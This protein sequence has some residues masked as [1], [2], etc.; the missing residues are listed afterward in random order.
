MI[1]QRSSDTLV[2]ALVL[3]T[4]VTLMT[5]LV[6][7][8]GWNKRQFDLYMW[9]ESALDLNVD[10]RVTLKDLP[11]GDVKAVVPRIDS[12]T[13]GLRFL[14]HLR[15]NERFSDGTE[16][17]LPLGTT[18]D[19]AQANAL[20]GAVITLKYPERAVGTLTPGD[21]ITSVRRAAAL[22]AITEIADSLQRRLS[23]VLDD[24]RKLLT[25]LDGAVTAAR[26]ELSTTAPDVRSALRELQ[27]T[28]AGLRPAL[29]HADTLLAEM[30]TRIPGLHDSLTAT[31]GQ[32]RSL[33]EHL[34]SLAL[35]AG[36][37]ASENRE[38][39]RKTVANL[40]VLSVK[41][42]H[43]MDQV[44]RRPLR[45]ITG[46]TPPATDSIEEQKP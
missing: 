20:G 44:S 42:E 11:I 14:V 8:Q 5:A 9:A 24:S 13:G 35:T 37:V 40:F 38:S 30:D 16:L 3:G 43:F 34:D 32:T 4:I 7:T 17:R 33:V 23:L 25:N 27:G 22:D 36:A 41:M 26:G 28:L 19:I 1:S 46:V 10:T 12:T 18:A 45:M 29:A 15:I 2:G 31:L 6:L 39:I 21:T